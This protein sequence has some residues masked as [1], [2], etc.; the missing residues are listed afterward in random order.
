MLSR[1]EYILQEV[2]LI[3]DVH[4][5]VSRKCRTEHID[6]FSKYSIIKIWKSKMSKDS[7]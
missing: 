7:N 4:F 1:D 2:P 6:Y 5:I 3:D